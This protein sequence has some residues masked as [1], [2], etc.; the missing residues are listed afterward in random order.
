MIPLILVLVLLACVTAALL[1]RRSRTLDRIKSIR[2]YADEQ[3]FTFLDHQLPGELDLSHSSV[4]EMKSAA[5]VFSGTRSDKRFVFFDCQVPS[6]R[7]NRTQSVLALHQYP[8]EYPAAR[9][10]RELREERSGEW[11]LI[12]HEGH[13][14]S[15]SEIDAHLSTL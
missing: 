10:D 13:A 15:V 7:T 11:K 6:G 9:W 12:Y 14:W 8:G 3:G 4:R 1:W 2:G 5:N